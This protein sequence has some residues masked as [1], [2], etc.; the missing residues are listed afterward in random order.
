VRVTLAIFELAVGLASGCVA[1]L[2]LT[3][4][5][6]MSEFEVTIQGVLFWLTLCL[7]PILLVVGPILTLA[8]PTGKLGSPLILAG[9]ATLTCWA[10]YFAVVDTTGQ[11]AG[12]VDLRRL[13]IPASVLVVA[14][15]SDVAA[16][17][18]WTLTAALRV[19]MKP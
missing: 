11:P 8:R 16:C 1:F 4:M 10:I 19:G 7:G 14:L 12:R 6:G 5:A 15:V 13:L 9:A 18:I 3:S 17:R 2:F